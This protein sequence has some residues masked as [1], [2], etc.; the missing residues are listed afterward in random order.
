VRGCCSA[1]AVPYSLCSSY[2]KLVT[3]ITS[4]FTSAYTFLWPQY[5]P[6][7]PLRLE[8][9]PVFDGRLVLRCILRELC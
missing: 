8:E 7:S 9:L 1:T 6:N 3:L 2:S 4:L 5:F